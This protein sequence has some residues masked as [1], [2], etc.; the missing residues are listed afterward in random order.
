[1]PPRHTA[2]AFLFVLLASPIVSAQPVTTFVNPFIGTAN[3]GNTFPGAVRPWGMVSV[4]PHNAPGA[5]S[6]YIHG[7]QWFYGL[8]HVHLSGTGCADLGS[9]VLTVSRGPVRTDPSEYRCI[10]REEKASPGYYSALLVEPDVRLE[11]TATERCGITRIVPLRGGPLNLL[12]DAGRSLALVGGGAVHW[13]SPTEIEGE[14]VAGG[15]CGEANRQQ[16]YFCARVSHPAS[17]YGVWRGELRSSETSASNRDSSVGAW[18]VVNASAGEPIT[19]RVGISYVSRTNARANLDAETSRL[20]FASLLAAAQAAWE[21]ELGKIRV[22][23]G[24]ADQ[25]TMFYTALYHS[26]IHPNVISDVNGE[27]PLGGRTGI[28]RRPDREHYSVFSL[29]DTYRTLHPLLTLV[30]PRR[31]S[32]IVNTMIDFARES[33]WLPKWELAGN[34]THMMVGDPAV[35][36]IADSYIKGIRDFDTSAAY[37]AMR[38][39]TAPT[40]TEADH[41]RPGY[42]DVIRSGYIPFEQDTTQ[43]WWVWGPVSTALE[44]CVADWAL[45]RMALMIGRTQD[46]RELRRRSLSYENLFDTGLLFMRPKLKNGRWLTPFDPL[47]TEGSGS[48]G[49][50]GGPGYVE[51]NAWNYTWFVPHDVPG[52]IQLFGGASAF[53]NKLQ[54]CFDQRHFTINNEPDIGYPYL[55][56]FVPGED[57][58]TRKIVR[59]IMNRDFGPGPAGLPGNDD[60]GTISA[61]YVFSALGFYPVCPASTTY[62]L[63]IPMFGKATIT[64]DRR[65]WKGKECVMVNRGIGTTEGGRVEV[66]GRTTERFTVE[67]Q[68][69]VNG[70][71]I[72]FSAPVTPRSP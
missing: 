25:R 37:E 46:E 64:L 66:N 36:V 29:W 6:G 43:E 15:F 42:R 47:A 40:G 7:G 53:V 19:V 57:Y 9:V 30:Y 13:M 24:T 35:P 2:F 70:G 18:M 45:S 60:A 28:G 22:E 14:N 16:V 4:S 63:G 34:E 54:E 11:A 23:G 32:A 38:K 58:R 33:G 49:G 27:Y 17:D 59:E 67:H 65:Y 55:F 3:G 44:Y 5:P 61:W 21:Q 62:Q 8:G 72:V 68:S 48:W 71:R 1:M 12:I 41:L 69:I 31:Q 56:T 10:A 39:P 52:L 50:S 51:G 26:L 20:S